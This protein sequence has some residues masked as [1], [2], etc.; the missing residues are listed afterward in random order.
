ML[1]KAHCE[2]LLVEDLAHFMG[3]AFLVVKLGEG[4]LIS[5]R[6]PF[7]KAGTSAFGR[8]RSQ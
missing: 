3:M 4:I 5:H 7:L 6:T 1:G 2:V 8:Q